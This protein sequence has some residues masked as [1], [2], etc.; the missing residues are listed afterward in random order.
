MRIIGIIPARYAST[1]FPGKPLVDIDGKSMIHRVYDRASACEALDEV[2]VATDDD[3]IAEKVEDFGGKS[4]MTLPSHESGTE[5]C[6]EALQKIGGDVDAVIN[7]QGDEPFI[8]PEQIASLAELIRRDEV[9]IATLVKRIEATDELLNPNKVKV[10]LGASNQALYFSRSPIPYYRDGD[11]KEWI[12]AHDFYRHLG[13]YAYRAST[14]HEIV[15]YEAG[16]LERAEKL[17]QLRWLERGKKIHC[18]ITKHESPA[19]DTPEDLKA[20]DPRQFI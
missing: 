20:L 5:R 11:I 14:L 3:R 17:E 12:D 4:V 15:H 10:V 16:V 13:L 18:G 6:L 9:E 7:I 1:R 8:A 2:W 19:I